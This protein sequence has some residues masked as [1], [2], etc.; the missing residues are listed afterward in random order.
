M[1]AGTKKNGRLEYKAFFA[2]TQILML[3]YKYRQLLTMIHL[4]GSNLA[5]ECTHGRGFKIKH[6]TDMMKLLFNNFEFFG[7]MCLE[8]R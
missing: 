8:M 4:K 5:S 6:V 2:V 1:K 3:K 7:N